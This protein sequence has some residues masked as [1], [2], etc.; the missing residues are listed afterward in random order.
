MTGW[1]IIMVNSFIAAK[2]IK[3][4]VVC[5]VSNETTA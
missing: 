5:A 1:C 4:H 3:R 2:Q